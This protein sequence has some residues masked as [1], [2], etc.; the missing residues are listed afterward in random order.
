MGFL[1]DTSIWIAVERGHLSPENI[2]AVTGSEPVFISPINIAEMQLGAE[3][4]E[5]AQYRSKCF[6][7]L[8]RLRRKPQI[9]ITIETGEVFGQTAA[10]L[11]KAGR[12][13]HFRVQDVW[14]AAQAIQRGFKLLT[15]NEKDFRD[16][17]GL[18]LITL[19]S[20]PTEPPSR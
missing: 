17:P 16:I 13:E 7:A 20:P 15:L 6:T 4:I 14:L 5:N 11:R 1:I 10:Q 2:Q 8:R 19:P 18:E 12:S 9:H 3:L